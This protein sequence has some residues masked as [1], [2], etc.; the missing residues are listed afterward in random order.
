MRHS[1]IVK[2]TNVKCTIIEKNTIFRKELHFFLFVY[3]CIV[4]ISN[5][6]YVQQNDDFNKDILTTKWMNIISRKCLMLKYESR[7][8]ETLKE[9][10]GKYQKW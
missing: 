9:S 2:S 6:I 10:R 4:N 8:I 1:F 7:S 3:N 5:I